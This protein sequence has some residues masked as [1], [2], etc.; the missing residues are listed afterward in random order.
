M[1]AAGPDM[2]RSEMCAEKGGKREGGFQPYSINVRRS[3]HP[4]DHISPFVLCAIVL[5]PWFLI[6]R[7]ARGR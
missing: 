7:V 5:V 2:L 3:R 6:G 4:P 1:K